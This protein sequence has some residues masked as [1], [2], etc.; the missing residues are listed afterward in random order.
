MTMGAARGGVDR[1]VLRTRSRIQQAHEALI[2]KKGY[3]ATTVKEICDAAKVGRSTFYAH[4]TGKA[5]LRRSC[6][7]GLRRH[8]AEH[9]RRA[10]SAPA[11]KGAGALAFSRPMFE[12]ARDYVHMYRALVGSH[13]A[14]IS[15]GEIRKIITELVQAEL[16][17]NGGGDDAAAREAAVAY[18]VG[19][20]MAVL[21]WWLES[22]AKLPPGRVDD[23]FRHFATEGVAP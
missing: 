15:M 11:A 21:T 3:E 19:A 8:L 16:R 20:F 17:G 13:G 5:D 18:V 10:H 1:R 12:H 4:F 23:L 22:G 6:F 2:L 14:A 9:Q 7:A